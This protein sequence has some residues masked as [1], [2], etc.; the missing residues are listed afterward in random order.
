MQQELSPEKIGD[1]VKIMQTF[2]NLN[3]KI[4]VVLL[5]ND[6]GLPIASSVDDMSMSTILA[7]ITAAIRNVVEHYV[8]YLALTGFERLIVD[9]K[10]GGLLITEL[11]K[12][13]YV[14]VFFKKP[15]PLGIILRD[16][17]NMII[18]IRQEISKQL[19]RD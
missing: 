6:E 14:L 2:V 17:Y 18:K 7:G 8:K 12:N 10:D 15:V 13:I 16:T 19:M 9:Y 3:D 11:N 1:I 4:E 5:C